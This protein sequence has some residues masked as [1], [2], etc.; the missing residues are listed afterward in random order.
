M[1]KLEEIKTKLATYGQEHLV[2]FVGELSDSERESLLTR[3]ETLDLELAKKLYDGRNDIS[4]GDDKI[5]PM[6]YVDRLKLSDEEN[7]KYIAI[8]EEILKAGKFASVTM[9][10]GQGTRLGHSGPKGTYIGRGWR[11]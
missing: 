11:N 6:A 7:A 3:L 9:A 2:A 10:G 1:S 5:E 4:T 8:G